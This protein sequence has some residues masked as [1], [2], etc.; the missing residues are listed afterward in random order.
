MPCMAPWRT[1]NVNDWVVEWVED[2]ARPGLVTRLPLCPYAKSAWDK[3]EVDVIYADNLWEAVSEA[4]DRIGDI[5]VVMCVRDTPEQE[6]EPIDEACAALNVWFSSQGK[7]IWLLA[8]QS[9]RTVVFVQRL[10]E[11]HN[12][13]AKMED[14]GYYMSYTPEDY[15]IL[16]RT[17]AD[18]A[19]KLMGDTL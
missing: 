17:R 14:R 9:S 15:D 1:Y 4:V 12:A 11:L 6:Y 8:H 10:S 2:L 3:E 5:K 19:K 7:D 16:I 13:S 18:A